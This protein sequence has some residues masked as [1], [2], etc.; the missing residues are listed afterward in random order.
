MNFSKFFKKKYLQ[1][2]SNLIILNFFTNKLIRIIL[3]LMMKYNTLFKSLLKQKF[4]FYFLRK[5]PTGI[6]RFN[7]LK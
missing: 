2:S 5:Y 6:N 4:K 3:S 7:P 1:I